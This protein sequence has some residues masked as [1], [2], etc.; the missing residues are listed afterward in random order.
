MVLRAVD[1]AAQVALLQRVALLRLAVHLPVVTAAVPVVLLQ[2]VQVA[3]A[4]LV[5]PV[6][7]EALRP[8][9]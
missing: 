8:N 6:V 9:R 3:L 4:V 5:A 2:V 7:A 1:L